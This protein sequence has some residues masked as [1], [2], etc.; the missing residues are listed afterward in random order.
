MGVRTVWRPPANAVHCPQFRSS[1]PGSMGT[2]QEQQSARTR[3]R[4]GPSRFVAVSHH[5]TMSREMSHIGRSRVSLPRVGCHLVTWRVSSCRVP[6]VIVSYDIG[7]DEKGDESHEVW[8]AQASDACTATTRDARSCRRRRRVRRARDRQRAGERQANKARCAAMATTVA[9]RT[10][11]MR[12]RDAMMTTTG[13]TARSRPDGVVGDGS[14]EAGEA[15]RTSKIATMNERAAE[16]RST[17]MSTKR[18]A[19]GAVMTT[20]SA[21]ECADD[22]RRR[23]RRH[24][25]W[26]VRRQRR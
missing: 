20:E 26:R 13:P 17:A 6:R 21:C 10:E 18:G 7:G 22:R 5:D 9:R 25:A 12:A 15:R 16:A 8:V 23:Q 1:R 11:R 14:R 4:V 24:Y 19:R 2:W 3:T